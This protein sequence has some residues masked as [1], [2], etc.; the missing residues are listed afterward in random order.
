MAP[1]SRVSL[2]SPGTLKSSVA[3]V[4]RRLRGIV[5]RPSERPLVYV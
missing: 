3:K 2:L 1:G 5:P 4:Q